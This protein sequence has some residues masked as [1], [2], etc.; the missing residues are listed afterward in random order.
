MKR[1]SMQELKDVREYAE[2]YPVFLGTLS[3]DDAEY[4][5][6]HKVKTEAGREVIVAYNEG[7]C[8]LTQVDLLDLI[9]WLKKNRPE[10]LK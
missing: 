7:G 6:K 9:D 10:L 8:D 4:A 1:D 5:D 3:R 2:F